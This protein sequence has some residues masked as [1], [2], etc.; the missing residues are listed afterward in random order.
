MIL[1]LSAY[2]VLWIVLPLIVFAAARDGGWRGAVIAHVSIAFLIVALDLRWIAGNGLQPTGNGL[3][4]TIAIT[5]RV[6][7][8]NAV[9]LPLSVIALGL[10]HRGLRRVA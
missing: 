4:T 6:L 5:L 10:R 1:Q 8:I 9:L 3:G 7:L 2:G